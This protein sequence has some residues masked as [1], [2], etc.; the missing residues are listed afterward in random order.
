MSWRGLVVAPERRCTPYDADDYRYPQS[1]EDRI[2]D[3]LGGVYGPYTG[4]WFA[5]KSDTDIEHMVARSE[6]HDSGS[7]RCRPR[8]P[9]SLRERPAEPDVGG[10]ARESLREGGPRR[11]RVA[12]GAEPLLVRGAGGRGPATV[13]AHRRPVGQNCCALRSGQ[14]S[15]VGWVVG[16]ADRP[17][18]VGLRVPVQV[19][20]DEPAQFP[21]LLVGGCPHRPELGLHFG[22]AGLDFGPAGLDFG[23][24]FGPQLREVLPGGHLASDGPRSSCHGQDYRCDDGGGC[25]P[26]LSFHGFLLAIVSCARSVLA[27]IRVS[28]GVPARLGLSLR[29]L[30]LLR[31]GSSGQHCCVLG[32]VSCVQA[33]TSA[34][35][36]PRFCVQRRK[37]L[38]LQR[39]PRG[40]GRGNTFRPT[41]GLLRCPA[42]P[43]CWRVSP[44]S[45]IPR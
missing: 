27:G 10:A 35:V 9:A 41:P 29:P 30:A 13:W 3:E 43:S 19:L 14:D 31:S 23:L 32:G 16:W 26:S 45:G 2:V 34:S 39:L 36:H 1:V 18:V 24:H 40:A 5:S 11:G 22:P 15:G 7:V 44:R 6:A 12:A 25:P 17:L 38:I 20:H 8:D 37:L 21:H 33:H 28:V 42:G 4:R